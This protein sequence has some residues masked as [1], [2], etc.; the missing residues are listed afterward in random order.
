MFIIKSSLAPTVGLALFLG[1]PQAATP[2]AA[3][4]PSNHLLKA[5]GGAAEALRKRRRQRSLSS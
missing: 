2:W 1:C 4:L 5:A 3:L